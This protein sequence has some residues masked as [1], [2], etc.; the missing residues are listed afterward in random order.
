MNSQILND[1]AELCHRDS[2]FPK[3]GPKCEIGPNWCRQIFYPTSLHFI[4]SF[5][6]NDQVSP[7]SFLPQ[8]NIIISSIYS[9]HFSSGR[10]SMETNRLG[11]SISCRWFRIQR[12]SFCTM[13]GFRHA[14]DIMTERSSANWYDQIRNQR[15]IQL[16]DSTEFPFHDRTTRKY[17]TFCGH[18]SVIPFY[19]QQMQHSNTESHWNCCRGIIWIYIGLDWIEL[20]LT[21]NAT[22][23]I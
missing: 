13:C 15:S 14:L 23:L 7:V 11:G 17:S 22:H 20:I 12:A 5:S 6:S 2:R 9:F 18:P 3:I 10:Q 8:L 19:Y 21:H 1:C 16:H 4:E